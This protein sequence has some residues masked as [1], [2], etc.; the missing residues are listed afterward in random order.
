MLGVVLLALAV[1]LVV[2]YL[3]G[4]AVA[5]L[6]AE[7]RDRREMDDVIAEF[8]PL[9]RAVGDRSGNVVQLRKSRGRR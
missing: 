4:E 5:A 7:I 1:V 2:G 6:R 8:G 9:R 3:L